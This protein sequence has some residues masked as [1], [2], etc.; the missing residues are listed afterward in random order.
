MNRENNLFQIRKRLQPFY[1]RSLS[2]SENIFTRFSYIIITD[3]L[4]TFLMKRKLISSSRIAHKLRSFA[5]YHFVSH[6]PYYP[7][8]FQ[9]AAYPAY[10]RMR[11]FGLDI[12]YSSRGFFVKKH[13]PEN[14]RSDLHIL[15][16]L[17]YRVCFMKKQ[18]IA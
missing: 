1:C 13:S 7:F 17:L 15:V 5:L 4:I 12:F 14:K 8:I 3:Y 9:H 18:K 2:F 16:K 11:I 6:I 10:I